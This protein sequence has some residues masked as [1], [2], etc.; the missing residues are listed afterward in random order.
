MSK[1]VIEEISSELE[2]FRN[3]LS[4]FQTTVSYLQNAKEIAGGAIETIKKTDQNFNLRIAELKHAYYKVVEYEKTIDELVLKIKN[5]NFPERLDKIETSLNKALGDLGDTKDVFVDELLKVTTGI[6]AVVGKID[7]FIIN[8][9]GILDEQIRGLKNEIEELRKFLQELDFKGIVDSAKTEL[10]NEAKAHAKLLVEKLDENLR[11]IVTTKTELIDTLHAKTETLLEELGGLGVS[12]QGLA[13][14][15]EATHKLCAKE[16]P[17]L[18][19]KIG[20]EA[21]KVNTH[22]QAVQANTQAII[23]TIDQ[24]DFP[25]QFRVIHSANTETKEN[26]LFVKNELSIVRQ[27]MS[28]VAEDLRAV[29]VGQL[30][31]RNILD[32]MNQRLLSVETHQND[33]VAK[34]SESQK[35]Q[36]LQFIIVLAVVVVFGIV[37]LLK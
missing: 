19:E 33:V 28:S 25:A 30:A 2:L 23:N 22:I 37:L 6:H 17:A 14:Q 16:F 3:K 34:L 8:Y 32:A 36:R 13:E 26:L 31:N 5:V 20:Q 1:K 7:E 9:Q 21:A 18:S 24:F 15:T 12:L 29:K 4:T 27:Q 35:A 11:S 10:N